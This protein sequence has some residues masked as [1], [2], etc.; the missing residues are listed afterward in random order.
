[1]HLALDIFRWLFHE[2]LVRK[3]TITIFMGRRVRT[4]NI[5]W[6]INWS[7]IENGLIFAH[8]TSQ[9]VKLQLLVLVISILL[10]DGFVLVDTLIQKDKVIGWSHLV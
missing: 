10:Q 8:S 3:N 6:Q 1:M 5:I 9:L 2:T 4:T 7:E